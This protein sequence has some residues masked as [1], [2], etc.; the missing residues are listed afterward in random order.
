MTTAHRLTFPALLAAIVVAPATAQ[1]TSPRAH[2]TGGT[3]V[4]AVDSG[5]ARFIGIPYAAPPVGPLRWRPPAPVV[6]WRGDR[7]ATAYGASCPQALPIR[8]VRPDSPAAAIS[9]DCLTLNVWAP[10]ARAAP[11]PVMVWLHGGGNF[12][13]T[14]SRFLYDG[15]AFARGG[16]ILV[17]LNYRLGPLGFFAH[18]ALTR[19]AGGGVAANFG[20]LDQFAALQW[21]RRNIAAFGGDAGNVT[22]FGESAGGQDTRTLMTVRQ[23]RGLF[24]KAIIESGGGGWTDPPALAEAEQAGATFATV[25]GLPGTAATAAQLRAV[26][27]AELMR[28]ASPDVTGPV[29]DGRLVTESPLVAFAAGRG[30]PIP[31]IIGTNS[32]EG[33]LLGAGLGA[34]ALLPRLPATVRDSLRR[35]YGPAAGNDVDF[36]RLLFRDGYFTGPSRWIALQRTVAPTWI[37]RFEYV[38]TVLRR[39]KTG[40]DHGFELPFVFDRWDIPQFVS[41]QDRRVAD[42]IHHCW[43]SFATTG[44]PTCPGVAGWPRYRAGDQRWLVFGDTVAVTPDPSGPIVDILQRILRPE[45]R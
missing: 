13:G 22:L 6:P 23:A 4:G 42:V 41:D 36:A 26:P 14:A 38:M 44:T 45:A 25:L 20:L 37:Y 31:L 5:V 8:G 39:R 2:V 19:E 32:D 29:I 21:V 28:A 7:P 9:E 3:V 33:S 16:V 12:E 17:S 27:L 35:L 18:P 34:A 43:V 40:T 15:T 1:S 10:V 24:Q 30:A 11:R